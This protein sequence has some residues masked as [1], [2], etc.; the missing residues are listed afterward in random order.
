MTGEDI[1][2]KGTS[3]V[4]CNLYSLVSYYPRLNEQRVSLHL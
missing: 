3:A 2:E 1:L 4:D